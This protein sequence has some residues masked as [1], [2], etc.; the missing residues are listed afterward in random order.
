MS[1]VDLRPSSAVDA[2]GDVDP[3]GYTPLRR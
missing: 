1:T 2:A 3:P